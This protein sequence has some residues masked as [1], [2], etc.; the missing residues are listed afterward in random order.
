MDSTDCILLLHSIKAWLVWIATFD[1][2]IYHM[3][4]WDN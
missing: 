2:H 3:S 4:I 1:L